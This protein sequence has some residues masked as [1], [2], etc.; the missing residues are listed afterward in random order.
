MLD[1]KRIR[2]NPDYFREGMRKR[3]EDET[4]I[5]QVLELDAARRRIL[6]EVESNTATVNRLSKEV[7]SAKDAEQRQGLIAQSR[8]LGEQNKAGQLELAQVEQDLNSLLLTLPMPPHSSVPIGKDDSENV[9]IRRVGEIRK[10]DFTPLPHWEIGEKLGIIDFE[11]GQKVFGA[12]GYALIG[13]GAKLERAL[14]NFFLDVH[15]ERHG[16]TEIYP[17]YLVNAESALGAGNLPKFAEEM[18]FDPKNEVYLIPTAEVPLT[19]LHRDEILEPG[20]LPINYVA[21]TPCFRTEIGSGGRD[22]RGLIRV[23]QFDKVE[24]VKFVEP[25]TSYQ[26]LEKLLQNALDILD[27]LKLPYRILEICTGDIGAKAT[28]QYDPEVWMAGAEDGQGKYVEISS[29]SNFEDFQ[30]RRANI[31]YRPEAEAKPEF[32]HTLNGS[33]LAVGRTFAAILE[34][35]QQADGSVIIPEVLRSYMGGLEVLKR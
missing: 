27:L 35:Y 25:Q 31:R 34:N 13:R 29:C 33:G 9:E 21:Y 8:A 23:H 20:T 30:G 11:R 28:K 4:A 32:V 26:E 3:H 10:F 19:N 24:M 6:Q 12:R 14:I 17:P 1:I 15:I 16:Y 22:K 7:R 5:D 2:E 18:Y